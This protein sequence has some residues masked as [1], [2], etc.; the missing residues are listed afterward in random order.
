MASET[1]PWH[2]KPNLVILLY[3][4]EANFD[5][6]FLLCRLSSLYLACTDFAMAFH[7]PCPSLSFL[8]AKHW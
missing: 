6:F 4:D 5:T 8:L 7:I 3:L 1:K 2:L